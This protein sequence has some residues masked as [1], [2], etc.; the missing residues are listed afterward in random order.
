MLQGQKVF[1]GEDLEGVFEKLL[2]RKKKIFLTN[3]YN[4]ID[5]PIH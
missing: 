2:I 4:E 3:V 5:L 1:G